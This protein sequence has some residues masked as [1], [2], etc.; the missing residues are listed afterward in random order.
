MKSFIEFRDKKPVIIDFLSVSC[1][2]FNTDDSYEKVKIYL[3]IYLKNDESPFKLDI[4]NI[5]ND[6][7]RKNVNLVI[8]VL[9]DVLKRMIEDLS[10]KTS[11]EIKSFKQF[12][13]S[14]ELD[15]SQC[16]SG[17]SLGFK[18]LD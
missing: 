13:E 11:V 10:N 15:Y 2:N 6:E 12:K 8:G 5:N 7:K 16:L 3:E 4:C 9:N 1:F 18:W 17:E 14:V